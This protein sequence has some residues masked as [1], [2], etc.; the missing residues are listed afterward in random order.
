MTRDN[1]RAVLAVI[2]S[3]AVIVSLI[4]WL[5]VMLYDL[6]TVTGENGIWDLREYSFED[7]R[8]YLT[9][10]V[11]YIPDDLLTPDEFRAREGEIVVGY[12]QENCQYATSRLRILVPSDGY[13]AFSGRS[14]G[15]SER[16]FVNGEWILDIGV[17]GETRETTI[18]DTGNIS[19]TLKA[20]NGIIEII[21]QSSNFVQRKGGSHDGWRLTTRD[22]RDFLLEDFNDGIKLGFFLALFFIHLLFY[23]IHR[24]YRANLYFALFC[25]MWFFRSGVTGAEIFTDILPYMTWMVKIRIEYLSFPVSA[26][27]IIALIN[28]LF[29]NILPKVFRDILNCVS[30]GFAIVF[31]AAN[32]V[33][34]SYMLLV[35]EIFYIS[36]IVFI[37]FCFVQKLR[38]VSLEQGVFL[39]GVGVF[40]IAAIHGIFY[41]NDVYY[42]YERDLSPSATLIL[43]FCGGAAVFIATMREVKTAKEQERIYA[44]ENTTLKENVRLNER[45]FAMQREQYERIMENAKAAKTMRHDIRH[46]LAVIGQFAEEGDSEKVKAYISELH[47]TVNTPQ[48]KVYC[49]NYAVNAVAAHYLRIAENEGIS[50]EVML[51]IPEDTGN[52]PAMDLCVILGNFLENAL[53][54]CRRM[55]KGFKYIRVRSRIDGDSLT[56]VVA[57]SY[58]GLWSKKDGDVYLS[59]KENEYVRD[60]I[61]ISSVKT[62]CE[63]HRGLAKFESGE[64]QWKSSALVHMK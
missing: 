30:L 44:T 35:Y 40:F 19:V 10:P 9:G 23:I 27:L 47:V 1:T 14:I 37:A 54:A 12:P 48:E 15:Y 59:R 57:N 28:A 7:N 51:N 56:I 60:G 6:K 53:E 45:Q 62:V 21:Q 42:F 4:L 34:T 33:F 41:Y 5:D 31:L 55:K 29:P 63:K 20:E 8:Y 13:Y 2:L 52:V 26:V 24:T 46:H 49:M 18:P 38:S 43:A 39:V 50:V 58:D 16:L 32:T 3:F 64:L 36:A 61:G 22:I 25:L 11:E 17:P